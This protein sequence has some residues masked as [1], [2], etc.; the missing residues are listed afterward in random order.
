M[1][2][3]A[4]TLAKIIKEL[5]KKH[6]D[7]DYASAVIHL[8]AKGYLPKK[9]TQTPKVKKTTRFASKAAGD[10]A[11]AHPEIVIPEDF[12]GTAKH[13]LISVSDLKTYTAPKKAKTNI[14][15]TARNFADDN[16]LDISKVTGTGVDGRILLKDIQAL[17]PSAPTPTETKPKVSA[18][19]AK[20]MKKHGVDEEVLVDPDSGIVG[21]GKNGTITKKDIMPYI[22]DLQA[23]EA[24]RDTEDG[25]SEDED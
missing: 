22:L 3:S 6:P 2:T 7:H 4:A 20:L 9:L 18:E 1:A 5:V 8:G 12:K 10:Y 15:H 11:E 14:S 17:K 13:G 21:T 16:G 23:D 24:D 19:V 25:S